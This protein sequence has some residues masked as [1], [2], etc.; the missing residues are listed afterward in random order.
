MWVQGGE[1]QAPQHSA[2][3]V[4]APQPHPQPAWVPSEGWGD[5]TPPTSLGLQ[6]HTATEAQPGTCLPSLLDPSGPGHTCSTGPYREGDL[7]VLPAQ[8][9]LSLE[10]SGTG[11]HGSRSEPRESLGQASC[12]QGACQAGRRTGRPDPSPAGH[13]TGTGCSKTS[14]VHLPA[15]PLPWGHL[16]QGWESRPAAPDLAQAWAQ[17]AP[18]G[19]LPAGPTSPTLGCRGQ[20][21]PRSP[22]FCP[23][24]SQGRPSAGRTD[25]GGCRTAVP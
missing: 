3:R 22:K 24:P 21:A 9:A 23:H 17:M 10:G 15:H 19:G 6:S 5:L 20:Q 18:C 12:Q 14:Q 1:G 4:W 7:K 25:T 8:G 2:A 13:L 16:L 11:L